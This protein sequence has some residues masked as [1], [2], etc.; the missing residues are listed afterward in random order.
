ML[1]FNDIRVN[2][3]LDLTVLECGSKKCHIFQLYQP[4]S[5]TLG[6]VKIY[7]NF[8]NF[9]CATTERVQKRF[10]TKYLDYMQKCQRKWSQIRKR[11]RRV[12]ENKL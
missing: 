10:L 6:N 12:N 3:C 1:H 7:Q 4:C 11:W 9:L 8:A 5:W 2:S